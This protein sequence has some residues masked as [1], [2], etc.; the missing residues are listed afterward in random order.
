MNAVTKSQDDEAAYVQERKK[1]R[2]K[3]NKLRVIERRDTTVTPDKSESGIEVAHARDFERDKD[4]IEQH[5]KASTGMIALIDRVFDSLKKERDETVELAESIGSASLNSAL[6]LS[7]AIRRLAEENATLQGEAESTQAEYEKLLS[8][9]KARLEYTAEAVR[10]EY[11]CTLQNLRKKLQETEAQHKRRVENA[12]EPG[13]V[14]GRSEV[15]KRRAASAEARSEP[16]VD[17]RLPKAQD[18]KAGYE[19]DQRKLRRSLEIEHNLVAHSQKAQFG[20]APMALKNAHKAQIVKMKKEHMSVME[21]LA[22][23]REQL[24]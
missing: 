10:T 1:T 4:A 13:T 2:N 6:D 24:E 17:Q 20:L 19:E 15:E 11:E 12:C 18:V 3:R 14:P 5:A 22:K 16:V 21:Q 7:T 8:E 9:E 23:K